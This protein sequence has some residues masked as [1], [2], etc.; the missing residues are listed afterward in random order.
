MYLGVLYPKFEFWQGQDT[1]LFSK[2]LPYRL[3]GPPSLTFNG[4]FG[5]FRGVKR[6]VHEV[7]D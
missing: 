7:V 3:W 5:S 2:K 1:F 6:T 4:H